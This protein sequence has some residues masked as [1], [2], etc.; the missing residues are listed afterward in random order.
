VSPG[1]LGL[2]ALLAVADGMGGH[3]AGE[4]ASNSAIKLLKEYIAFADQNAPVE[5]VLKSALITANNKI[6]TSI[7]ATG[8]SHPGTTLTVAAVKDNRC[9]ITHVGD[10]RAYILR[11][12]VLRQLTED[13]SW[14]AEL[15]RQGQMTPD[16]ASNWTHKNQLT[17][18][19]GIRDEVEPS[20]VSLDLY[21][22]DVILVCS[23]GLHGMISDENIRSLLLVGQSPV[24][25]GEA[26]CAAANKAGGEDNISVVIYSHGPWIPKKNPVNQIDNIKQSRYNHST[27][28]NQARS[29]R[30]VDT[31]KHGSMEKNLPFII[32][33]LIALL[34]GAGLRFLTFNPQS[35]ADRN[36]GSNQTIPPESSRKQP[37]V[38]SLVMNGGKLY[39]NGTN[40]DIDEVQGNGSNGTTVIYEFKDYDGSVDM[41]KNKGAGFI[42]NGPENPYL[43][44]SGELQW[45]AEVSTSGQYHILWS[46]D[47][48]S[49]GS[50]SLTMK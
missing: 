41:V 50:F 1:P 19:I 34:L 26:L 39:I 8:L 10:S 35:L 38:I 30:A 15:V 33:A 17:K 43:Q 4:W 37:A 21:A 42:I 12:S 49:M 40:C 36:G 44:P 22:G 45:K 7:A 5:T 14:A 28:T 29:I 16:A 25:V 9:V 13:D 6:F 32:I 31:E 11:G 2:T 24:Q 48:S 46:P 20:V 47:S 23:D 3:Q 18:A 27:H